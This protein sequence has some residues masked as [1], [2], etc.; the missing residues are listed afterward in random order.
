MN[1]TKELKSTTDIVKRIL[2]E[3][4]FA[5][6]SD[7]YLYFMVCRQKNE[8]MVHLP[9]WK[10]MLNRKQYKFPSFKSVERARRKLQRSHPEF[11]GDADVEAQRELNEEVFK[12]YARGIV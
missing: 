9:F 10:V 11:Y 3:D 6:N 2:E 4:A 12:E 5:R 1:T 8:I 7:D